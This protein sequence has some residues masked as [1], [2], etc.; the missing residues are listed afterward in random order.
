VGWK[1]CGALVTISENGCV[2]GKEKK[3]GY[4]VVWLSM[5]LLT[6]VEN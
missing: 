3:E 5:W 4:E 6:N 2:A 1:V